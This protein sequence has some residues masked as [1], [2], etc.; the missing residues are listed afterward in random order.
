MQMF[1]RKNMT[2]GFEHRN[3]MDMFEWMAINGLLTVGESYQG[4][5]H[6][7]VGP[8]LPA[9]R[10]LVSNTMVG[11]TQ[12]VARIL[13]LQLTP[14]PE[15]AFEELDVLMYLWANKYMQLEGK[16]VPVQESTLQHF[17]VTEEQLA[18]Y[19]ANPTLAVGNRVRMTLEDSRI[20]TGVI[21]EVFH[22]VE[23]GIRYGIWPDAFSTL[24]A[25]L[26]AG[27][28]MFVLPESKLE[29]IG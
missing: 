2:C 17:V 28:G 29:L 6:V 27:S 26:G 24:K 3:L 22:A 5:S 21:G 1:Y 16:F 14:H 4:R 10:T 23:N 8:D 18:N 11:F 19:Y 15:T 13:D 9:F 25:E 7:S 12:N 20:F